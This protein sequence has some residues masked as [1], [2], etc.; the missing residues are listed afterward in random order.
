MAWTPIPDISYMDSGDIIARN[1]EALMKAKGTNA[2]RLAKD[3][4]MGHTGVRDIILRKTEN[5]KHSTLE[6]LADI[7]GVPVTEITGGPG[8]E[9][10]ELFGDAPDG[11]RLVP[12]YDVAA[13]AGHGA[14]IEGEEQSHSLA[15]PPDYLQRLTRSSPGNLAI[16]GVKG[17]SMEPTIPDDSIVL[18]DVTKMNLGYDGLFVIRF[19]GVLQ[20]KRIGRASESGHIQVLSDNPT[21][22]DVDRRIEDVEPIGKVIWYGRKV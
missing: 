22:R 18:L 15:F 5:P 4:G 1:L 19:D 13:S 14:I 6:G 3:A 8:L 10:I 9:R 12:V 11:T 20:I 17:D 21:Y 2:S 7:L 16:I